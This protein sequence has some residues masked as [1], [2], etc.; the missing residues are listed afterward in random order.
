MKWKKE[1]SE[2]AGCRSNFELHTASIAVNAFA[3][4]LWFLALAYAL[5]IFCKYLIIV[6]RCEQKS[7]MVFYISA[8]FDLTT[9]ISYFVVSCFTVQLSSELYVISVISSMASVCS[10]LSHSQ[11]LIQLIF[12]LAVVK[13]ETH[14]QYRKLKCKKLTFL[15]SLVVI[16]IVLIALC[17]V[18]ALISEPLGA[19]S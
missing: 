17:T 3:A 16:W 13:C 2:W 12:D 10:G 5:Y 8:M 1:S 15:Y 9:R 11:N 4:S 18:F 19:I 7:M 6:N 14:A